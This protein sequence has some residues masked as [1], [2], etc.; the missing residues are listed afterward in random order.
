M[1]PE[2]APMVVFG[3]GVIDAQAIRPALARA[4]SR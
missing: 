2:A 4:L 3:Y 1:P